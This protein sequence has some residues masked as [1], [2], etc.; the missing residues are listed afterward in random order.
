MGFVEASAYKK[1]DVE[2]VANQVELLGEA[3]DSG[4]ADVDA[5]E[6]GH[7]EDDEQDGE[8]SEVKLPDKA[9]LGISSIQ[10][11]DIPHGFLIEKAYSGGAAQER[12]RRRRS[13]PS[14]LGLLRFC[15]DRDAPRQAV[16]RTHHNSQESMTIAVKCFYVRKYDESCF[17]CVT[18]VLDYFVVLFK[19][20]RE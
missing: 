20:E 5:V 10:I 7:H 17:A 13:R 19:S 16:Q 12:R 9:L 15:G 2:P 14:L 3:L 18:E 4:I 11:L 8:D 6:E 1:C